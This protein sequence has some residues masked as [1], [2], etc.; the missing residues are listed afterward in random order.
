MSG[1]DLSTYG[2]RL[3]DLGYAGQVIDL[4]TSGLCNYKNAGETPIDFGLFVAR[5]PKDATCKA[6]MVQTPPSWDQCPPCHD[7]GRCGRTG[8]LC[9]PCDGAGVGDRSHPGDLRGWLPPG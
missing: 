8:P 4:N 7:G 2:G 3:L 9:P 5:G 6:P 1:I